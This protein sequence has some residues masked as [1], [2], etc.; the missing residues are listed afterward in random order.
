MK[1]VLIVSYYWPPSGG[2]GVQRWLKL[3]K[4]LPEWG[5]EPIILTP[6]NPA[7]SL[8]DTTLLEEVRPETE[9]LRLPIWE[10]Y[11]LLEKVKGKKA[12]RINQGI[13]SEGEAAGFFQQGLMWIRGNFFLPDPR[14]FWVKPATDFILRILETNQISAIIT[15]G[16]PH[17]MHL[18][19][20]R[21]KKK[22]GITWLADF[23]DPWSRWEILHRM[24]LTAPA[25]WY[26]QQME[27]QV[28]AL[29]DLVLSAS[30]GMEADFR[31]LCPT[32]RV[33]VLTNG[34]DEAD[35]PE[36]FTEA[37][38]PNKFR[39]V[40]AGLLN[41]KRNPFNLWKALDELCREEEGFEEE[42]EISLTGN[43]GQQVLSSLQEYPVLEKRLHLQPSVP[44]REVF[45]L[46][47]QAA[48][49]L[50]LIDNAASSR[51][52]IPAKLFEYLAARK[53]VLYIGEPATDAGQII[54]KE[55]CGESFR[56]DDKEGVKKYV[57]QLF[58]EY[59]AG[60]VME[61]RPNWQAYTR[62]LQAKQ[63]AGW[64]DA[65]SGEVNKG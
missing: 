42:L 25:R 16:P 23:R 1:K 4:Y 27:K 54:R 51:V 29:A 28:L 37:L 6:E 10:P 41:D 61:R 36:G 21:V 40:Y 11:G 26:H 43:I 19:G 38:R 57:R 20:Q 63:L 17:S 31:S 15:T 53:P 18:I 64:L 49:L 24:K 39:L 3:A 9:V 22:S 7:F 2:V 56:F 52:I 30:Y 58:Q 33:Q 8:Q 14:R 47:R 62:S 13:T 59:K 65:G 12:A 34:V 44:H 5:W 50:L 35:L 46:Y 45:A 48:V 60:A 55:H 32:A